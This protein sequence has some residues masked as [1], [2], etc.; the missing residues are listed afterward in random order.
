MGMD[1]IYEHL[2]K[3]FTPCIEAKLS[4]GDIGF[5]AKNVSYAKPKFD[6]VKLVPMRT[7]TLGPGLGNYVNSDGCIELDVAINTGSSS[8]S[9][10]IIETTACVD[11]PRYLAIATKSFREYRFTPVDAEKIRK[12]HGISVNQNSTV[13]R[14]I[15]YPMND[16]LLKITRTENNPNIIAECSEI[17]E[18]YSTLVS[19]I[20]NIIDPTILGVEIFE[21]LIHA[22]RGIPGPHWNGVFEYENPISPGHWITPEYVKRYNSNIFGGSSSHSEN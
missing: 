1:N 19:G 9:A 4:L 15:M 5:S 10:H 2:A 22:T 7:R 8:N 12:L 21:E 16:E 18:R 6:E 14:V 20:Y 3:G 11:I 17:F 13:D